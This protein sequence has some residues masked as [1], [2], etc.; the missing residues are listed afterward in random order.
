MRR[1]DSPVAE[2]TGG[3]LDDSL[4]T[5]LV[6]DRPGGLGLDYGRLGRYGACGRHIAP[7]QTP[8]T[9]RS[10]SP[11]PPNTHRSPQGRSCASRVR[12]EALRASPRRT[13]NWR[14]CAGGADTQTDSRMRRRARKRIC[15]GTITHVV[16]RPRRTHHAHLAV[17]GSAVGWLAD[18]LR[19][20]LAHDRPGG[21]GLDSGRL[22]RYGACGWRECASAAMIE[23]C[24]VGWRLVQGAD[25]SCSIGGVARRSPA[26][27]DAVEAMM[28]TR[29]VGWRPVQGGGASRSICSGTDDSKTHQ[30]HHVARRS[31][32]CGGRGASRS[33]ALG[34]SPSGAQACRRAA[35]FDRHAAW[36]GDGSVAFGRGGVFAAVGG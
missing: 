18:S 35:Q 19:T 23:G 28:G 1:V 8:R 14:A 5:R 12:S 27:G 7:I 11:E 20:R 4:R 29:L 22:G 9:M 32:S 10:A 21:L 13:W 24:C 6:H 33:H 3:W 26:G 15:S 17:S 36:A 30:T 25:A 34:D 16:P 31:C 2:S